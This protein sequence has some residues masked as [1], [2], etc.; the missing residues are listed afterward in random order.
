MC[1]ARTGTSDGRPNRR[2]L[3]AEALEQAGP[4]TREGYH[5]QHPGFKP[6]YLKDVRETHVRALLNLPPKSDA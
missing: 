2:K 3:D 5:R 1:G 4:E 6:L